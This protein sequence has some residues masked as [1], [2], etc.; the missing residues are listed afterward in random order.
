[1]RSHECV[2]VVCSVHVDVNVTLC[3]LVVCLQSL[4]PD[5]ESSVPP[6]RAGEI[7][8]DSS[9]K[10]I[11][12]HKRF[13][14]VP[15]PPPVAVPLICAPLAP[16]PSLLGELVKYVRGSLYPDNNSKQ[17]HTKCTGLGGGLI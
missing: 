17:Q 4:W 5:K 11:V 14:P 2:F 15:P 16:I 7:V 9:P 13:N 1:M 10:E 3:N 8:Y 12:F 6:G